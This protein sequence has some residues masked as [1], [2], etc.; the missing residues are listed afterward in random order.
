MGRTR[1]GR[2]V[3]EVIVVFAGVYGAFALDQYRSAKEDEARRHQ[4]LVALQTDFTSSQENLD[5]AVPQVVAIVDSILTGYEA[6]EKP[7]IGTLQFS[8]T[9]RSGTWD[10]ILAS[11]G[12]EILDIDL[13]FAVEDYYE[14]V[15]ALYEAASE[16]R[17]LSSQFI[18]PVLDLGND[19]FYESEGGKLKRKYQ[20]FISALRDYRSRI[21]EIQAKNREIID[22]VERRL[23]E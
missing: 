9:F 4:I 19:V 15:Q 16:G 5:A 6:G 7:P 20:W 18:L 11:G 17:R 10:A 13:I 21:V 8:L 14:S 2:L 3:A 22:L 1:I 12:V 23:S